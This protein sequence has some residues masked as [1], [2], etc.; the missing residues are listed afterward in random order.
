M[1]DSITKRNAEIY[2]AAEAV[3]AAAGALMK[4]IGGVV[5]D[6]TSYSTTPTFQ[7]DIAEAFW[8]FDLQH[9]RVK[10][11]LAEFEKL[12]YAAIKNR[13][14]GLVYLAH[15]HSTADIDHRV[16]DAFRIGER[17]FG[18]CA[19]IDIVME[20]VREKDWAGLPNALS[21][22]GDSNPSTV[23]MT[24]G[25]RRYLRA[26]VEYRNDPT[27]ERREDVCRCAQE[28]IIASID[29]VDFVESRAVRVDYL[30]EFFLFLG[31]L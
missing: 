8:A 26:F 11:E 7:T 5:N 13:V 27:A 23:P 4:T 31:S 17:P 19:D 22:Y 21:H 15:E 1:S 12:A 29:A 24:R 20:A 10:A 28:S 2:V 30:R 18:T 25:V 16:I 3:R 14:H 6:V 9:N